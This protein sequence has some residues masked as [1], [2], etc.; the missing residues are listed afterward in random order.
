MFKMPHNEFHS[1]DL[2]ISER[3]TDRQSIKIDRARNER[4]IRI[5]NIDM[6][7]KRLVVDYP[8]LAAWFCL[9]VKSRYEFAVEKALEAADIIACVPRRMGQEKVHR[10]RKIPAPVLPVI[11]G[12]VLVNCVPSPNAFAGL[13]SIDLVTNIMRN[14]EVPFRLSE[15]KIQHFINLAASG[16]YDHRET[17]ASFAVGQKVQVIDGPFASFPAIVI[18]IG[19]KEQATRIN[20]EVNIFGR[21]TSVE[22]DLAQLG[23][24]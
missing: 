20:V 10:G 9:S 24:V 13:R 17:K 15:K 4:A 8:E 1:V 7:S 11:P 5:R 2:V 3:I 19:V 6:A 21:M 22:L 23:K 14:G 12:Y 18:S 16:G